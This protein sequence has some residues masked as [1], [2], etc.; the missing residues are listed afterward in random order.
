MLEKM[1]KIFTIP[2]LRMKILFILALLVVFRIAAN[3]PLP[4]VNPSALENSQAFGL[5]NLFSGGGFSAISIVLLGL[6]PYITASIIMQLMTMIVP[7]VERMHKEEGDAGRQKFNTI[8][9]VLTVPLAIMQTFAMIALLKSQGVVGDVSAFDTAV[10]V[11]IATAGTIFLM[12]LGELIT[13]KKLGNGVSVMIFA[14]IVA[15]V[16]SLLIQLASTFAAQDIGQY[17]LY[18]AMTLITIAG[19]VFVSE[20]QRIVPIS[21]ARRTR[22]GAGGGGQARTHLPIKVNQAGVIPIIFAISLVTFPT[23]IGGFLQASTNPAYN[24][25]GT[26]MTALF[27]NPVFYGGL[28]FGLVVLFTYFYTAVIFDPNKIAKNLQKQGGY[29]D[30]VRPGEETVEHLAHIVS[31]ITLFGALFLGIIAILPLMAG[32]LLDNSNL[33]VGGTSILIVVSVV[34]E[35]I[36]QIDAQ[37]VMHN[38][39]KIQ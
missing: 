5:L 13:E 1:T 11:T 7:S 30:G 28:Y 3:I 23:L 21:Y 27:A 18:I 39:E 4:G 2:D 6:G 15:S 16:P 26:S 17:V 32:T 31:R 35:L 8:T 9:R 20:G 12:W 22:S 19:V 10:L 33:A 34:I 36:K 24:S 14:G 37:L 25:I 29:I 38:Y